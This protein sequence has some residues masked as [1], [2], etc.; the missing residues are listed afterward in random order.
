ML[1]VDF[2]D[3][4]SLFKLTSFCNHDMTD[5]QSSLKII[6][7]TKATSSPD[8]VKAAFAYLM[9]I[10]V[11]HKTQLSLMMTSLITMKLIRMLL[12]CSKLPIET[13]EQGVK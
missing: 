12:A 1:S 13:L 4:S 3:L 2:S 5:Y 9:F 7:I 11:F 6:S 8:L 10:V